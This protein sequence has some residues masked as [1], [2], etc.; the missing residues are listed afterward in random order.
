MYLKKSQNSL[1]FGTEE[2][3]DGDAVKDTL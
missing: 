1:Q 2:V 3:A